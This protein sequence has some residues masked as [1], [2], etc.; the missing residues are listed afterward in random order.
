MSENL[1]PDEDDV[2]QASS[3]D[4]PVSVLVDTPA[5]QRDAPYLK[6][7]E[8]V[9]AAEDDDSSSVAPSA[10]V[11][12]EFSNAADITYPNDKIDLRGVKVETL[13]ELLSAD[14]D[15]IGAVDLD[16]RIHSVGS[17]ENLLY[18]AVVEPNFEQ[19]R[20]HAAMAALKDEER[21]GTTNLL[22]GDDGKVMLRIASI[23]AKVN[24]GEIRTVTGDDALSAFEGQKRGGSYRVPLY[25]S[26]IC[27]DVI[28][29][30]GNDIETLLTNCAQLDRQLGSTMGLHYFAY[31]DTMYKNQIIEFL[32]PLIIGSSYA[33][34]RKNNQLWSVIKLPD[35]GGLVCLL[36][37]LCYK[38][39]FDGFVTTCTR[40]KS[41]THPDLCRHTET[42]TANIFDLIV[43]RFPAMSRASIEFMMETRK[44]NV[45]HTLT[46]IARYQAGLGL[47]GDRLEF[48]DITFTMRIPSVAEHIEAG[49][50]FIAEILNEVA[51]DNTEGRYQAFDMR[52]I[53]TFVPWIAT[54]EQKADNGGIVKSA[55]VRVI[56]RELEKLD[57]P[58]EKGVVQG[59]FV[60]YVNKSQLTYVGYPVTPCPKCKYVDETET[61][62]R[63]FDPFSNFFT[64]A[65]LSTRAV[66]A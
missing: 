4:V 40:P 64:L 10:A 48:G 66:A 61:G 9:L 59:R 45:K 13:A 23:L 32:Q 62:M 3:E 55:D 26:G 37:A 43:T 11:P 2:V 60:D 16:Q 21:K 47:E 24:P 33:D 20:I 65:L 5:V 29:P 63:S 12:A 31:N 25:N 52:Y 27:V 46:D 15:I 34:F 19:L 28:V 36:A 17:W 39:G 44:P 49:S 58:D 53:R 57:G 38:D 7:D 56:T 18:R 1:P 50:R 22:R 35:L 6:T 14:G 8:A 41:E 54:V 30:T 42:I 51:G